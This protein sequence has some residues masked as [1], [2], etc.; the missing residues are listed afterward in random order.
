MRATEDGGKKKGK[1]KNI[2]K[3]EKVKKYTY[4]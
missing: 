2:E 4:I 3:G 1:K